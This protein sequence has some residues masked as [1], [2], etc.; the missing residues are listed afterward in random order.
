MGL[1][2]AHSPA[3]YSSPKHGKAL[4]W[5]MKSDADLILL[6]RKLV[7]LLRQKPYGPY[8]ATVLIFGTE[9]ANRLA[10]DT[11]K[12]IVQFPRPPPPRPLSP[13]SV[14]VIEDEEVLYTPVQGNKRRRL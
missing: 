5:S 6:H 14:I 8:K 7:K 11:T 12:G 1:A 4:S 2:N 9:V 3:I 10:T 13:H